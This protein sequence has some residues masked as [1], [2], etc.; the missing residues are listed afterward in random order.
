MGTQAIELS[1]TERR[2]LDVYQRGLPLDPRPFARVADALGVSEQTVLDGLT[3]LQQA[4]VIS[5]V[6]P[7]FRPNRVGVST[8]AALAVP[9]ERLDEVART[10][11][12]Y[13]EVNHN[14]E[15][16]HDYNLWFVVTARDARGLAQVLASIAAETGLEPLDLPMLEDYFIDLGFELQWT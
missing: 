6:G 11:S 1:A 7:V 3:R 4:G 9:S 8:L 16:E 2:L 10:V 12:G 15:R 14:Y 5:R 13:A